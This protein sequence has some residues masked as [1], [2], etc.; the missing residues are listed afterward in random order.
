M[1]NSESL[2]SIKCEYDLNKHCSVKVC[3]NAKEHICPRGE[4]N[5]KDGIALS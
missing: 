3:Q 5:N 4:I 2:W 1:F